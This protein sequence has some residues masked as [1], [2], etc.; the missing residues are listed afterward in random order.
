MQPP[1]PTKQTKTGEQ[2]QKHQLPPISGDTALN[3]ESTGCK[4]ENI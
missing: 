2:E 3:P 4:H 1:P